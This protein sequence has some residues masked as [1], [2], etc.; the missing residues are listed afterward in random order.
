M[1]NK[2]S[3]TKECSSCREKST[4]DE[5]N[6]STAEYFGLELTVMIKMGDKNWEQH[7]NDLTFRCP[8]C[9]HLHCADDIQAYNKASNR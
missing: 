9:G 4:R 3:L 8:K 2:A 6:K 7:Y 1:F 5:W